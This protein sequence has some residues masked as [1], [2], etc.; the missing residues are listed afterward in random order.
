MLV[1]I[2]VE[3]YMADDQNSN[4]MTYVSIYIQNKPEEL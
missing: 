3:A 1:D 2:M 4:K